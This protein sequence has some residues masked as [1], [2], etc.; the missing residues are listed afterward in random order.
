ML[1]NCKKSE[2]ISTMCVKKGNIARQNC[3][4]AR[5]ARHEEA[6]HELSDHPSSPNKQQITLKCLFL[7]Y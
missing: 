5:E 4:K 2:K 1:K 7:M 3:G 6:V